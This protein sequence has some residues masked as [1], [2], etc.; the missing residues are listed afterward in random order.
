M[1]NDIINLFRTKVPINDM[2]NNRRIIGGEESDKAYDWMVYTNGCG[3]S[4]I[5]PQWVLSAD[6]CKKRDGDL[7]YIGGK[8]LYYRYTD[9]WER[10]TVIQSIKIADWSDGDMMLYKLDR[11]STK[12][13]I[14]L[15][16]NENIGDARVRNIGWGKTKT[17]GEIEYKLRVVDFDLGTNCSD[18]SDFI[19]S[20]G[21]SKGSCLGD[22]GGPL[23]IPTSI[24]DVQVGVVSH[25]D[26]KD[27]HD[28]I[29]YYGK[30][31][32]MKSKIQQYVPDSKWV[33]VKNIKTVQDSSGE[34][35]FDFN[36]PSCFNRMGYVD[37]KSG[38]H[39]TDII[40]DNDTFGQEPD[41]ENTSSVTDKELN[42]KVMEIKLRQGIDDDDKEKQRV[43]F[44]AGS[45]EAI[46]G[47]SRIYMFWINPMDIEPVD[48]FFHFFQIKCRSE[49]ISRPGIPD[50]GDVNS[51]PMMVISFK[52]KGD[53]NGIGVSFNS[54]SD[55]ENS[56]TAQLIPESE[57]H[58][59]IQF[60]V[61]LKYEKDS[62]GR[63][64]VVAANRSGEVLGAIDF[65]GQ[66]FWKQAAVARPRFGLYRRAL[67]DQDDVKARWA[68]LAIY[69]TNKRDCVYNIGDNL[70]NNFNKEDMSCFEKDVRYHGDTETEL[71]DI[72]SEG[73]CQDEC[74]SDS[75]CNYFSYNKK[76]KE[77]RLFKSVRSDS[78]ESDSDY[79]SGPKKCKSSS[80]PNNGYGPGCTGYHAYK[81]GTKGTT[82]ADRGLA[83][84]QSST[85]QLDSNNNCSYKECCIEKSS[86]GGGGSGPIYNG[87]FGDTCG[88]FWNLMRSQGKAECPS[89]YTKKSDKKCSVDSNGNCSYNDCCTQSSSGG[90]GSTGGNCQY[91]QSQ[92]GKVIEVKKTIEIGEGKVFDGRG[93][94]YKPVGL[95]DGGQGE[96]QQKVFQLKKGA[97]LRNLRI[98]KP[99][100]DGVGF[101]DDCLIENVVW[102][103]IGEDAMSTSS[104]SG[105]AKITVINCEFREAK[106]K[107]IQFNT[108]A[109]LYLINCKFYKCSQPIRSHHEM[110]LKISNCIFDR[111]G[112]VSLLSG[113]KAKGR[114]NYIDYYNM[115]TKNMGCSGTSCFQTGGYNK[116]K[117]S[118]KSSPINPPRGCVINVIGPVTS[119]TTPSPVN[120]GWSSW[121]GWSSC[122]KSCGGGNQTRTR[123]CNNPTPKNGGANCSGSTTESRSCNTQSCVAPKI[124]Q[125]SSSCNGK[126]T[127][128]VDAGNKIYFKSGS[129]N[130]KLVSGGLSKVQS[131]EIFVYGRN[132][133][134][135]FYRRPIADTT[136]TWHHKEGGLL[137]ITYNCIKKELTGIG[138][139][140]NPYKW[141]DHTQKWTRIV[142]EPT[143]D[144]KCY[145]KRYS[146]I[147]RH[148]ANGTDGGC[149][150]RHYNEHGKKE[151]RLWGCDSVMGNWG[152]WSSCSKSCGG[153]T[154]TRTRTCTP[155]VLDGTPCGPTT[156]SKSCNTQSCY[157]PPTI[158]QQST[159]CNGKY[160]WGVDVGNQIYFKSGTSN[161]KKV[162]GGLTKVQCSDSYVYGTN[163]VNFYLRPITDTTGQ[164]KH[165]PQVQIKDITYNCS[166]KELTGIGT[167]NN[168]YKWS[169]STQKWTR[170]G[171]PPPPPKPVDGKWSNWSAWSSCDKSCDGGKQKRTRTC[172]PPQHGGKV[173]EGP[174]EETRDCN[175]Q[176]CRVCNKENRKTWGYTHKVIKGTDNVACNKA[177]QDDD[178]CIVA[179]FY[180]KNGNCYLRRYKRYGNWMS[181]MKGS[182][183]IEDR[184][185]QFGYKLAKIDGL[186]DVK[187]C[188]TECDGDRDCT[189]FD[190]YKP[191]G[192]CY[193]RKDRGTSLWNTFIDGCDN[194]RRM[195]DLEDDNRL[196]IV[197][198]VLTVIL[199][200]LILKMNKII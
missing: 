115:Q 59:W 183:I 5:A 3:A 162:Y 44:T 43:E 174:A 128:G 160:T 107:A 29:G 171:I 95:G 93:A 12:K 30:V 170:I 176:P 28:A 185:K 58:Q 178:Q 32:E 103:D 97:T 184:K 16:S 80:S 81:K 38:K 7:I 152:S 17:S 109:E 117:Y 191:N 77:C 145:M 26:A 66:T 67:D 46:P 45:T 114:T 118:K 78:D 51:S 39:P 195:L 100:A 19:C 172:T 131:G 144:E 157:V 158:K 42:R 139:D 11:P 1:L 75:D 31:A 138:T 33:D 151:G 132:S 34:M 161:W 110:K 69:E 155:H 8:N 200:F 101:T 137:D 56:W 187:K 189:H 70:K 62:N 182:G 149:A 10:R 153:G 120:G 140:K 169:D 36:I 20:E 198:V 156:E 150:T 177:C 35:K 83:E 6:H 86:D 71:S 116:Q 167:D 74:D 193:L 186:S 194:T 48:R 49:A 159:S 123:A 180:K 165:I 53:V 173:C 188:Q 133:N 124:V 96:D 90:G 197:G 179:D 199:I 63:V 24:G 14:L 196:L 27:C 79:I 85:C 106:D 113:G 104:G 134:N 148:C 126:Y 175:M 55:Y 108:H 61:Y 119:S 72:S 84:K 13:P 87:G 168:P 111:C 125:Q 41:K 136:G 121:S 4:L 130:W 54:T 143:R 82:C 166:T 190:F 21:K 9:K 91:D 25:G 141:N 88:G 147:F 50:G 92:K 52:D 60:M 112:K 129:S 23:F 181:G 142:T 73:E 102:E 65:K 37:F 94:T 47:E 2:T 18:S 105:D 64:T 15:N 146:D 99:G 164:W 163:G 127:W 192:N 122:S 68:A 57:M 135:Q 154:Q 40:D 98:S 76:K 89:G 22:S